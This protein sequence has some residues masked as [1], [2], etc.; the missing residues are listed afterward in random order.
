[1]HTTVNCSVLPVSAF[2]RESKSFARG[3]ADCLL[4]DN[5]HFAISELVS[6]IALDHHDI[7]I[8]PAAIEPILFV[9]LGR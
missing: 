2:H 5:F 1:M 4:E 3:V 9:L 8:F 6:W 7:R